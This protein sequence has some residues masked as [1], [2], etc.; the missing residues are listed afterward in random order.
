VTDFI[1]INTVVCRII[2]THNLRRSFR[3]ILRLEHQN[4]VLFSKT[5]SVL[6]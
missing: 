5:A 1:D 6:T 2:L 3:D 4:E